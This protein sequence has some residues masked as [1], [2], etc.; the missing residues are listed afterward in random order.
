MNLEEWIK[1]QLAEAP[2][3]TPEQVQELQSILRASKQPPP[4]G[5]QIESAPVE[6]DAA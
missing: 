6:P 5:R 2:P 3:L 1:E 4:S